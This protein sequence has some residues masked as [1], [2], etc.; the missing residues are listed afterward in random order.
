MAATAEIDDQ[1]WMLPSDE[2]VQ[3]LSNLID[4]DMVETALMTPARLIQAIEECAQLLDAQDVPQRERYVLVSRE[5]WRLAK[6]A[7]GRNMFKALPRRRG[8]RG[9]KQALSWSPTWKSI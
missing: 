4:A 5:W 1:G 8:A 9:R 6:R 2:A 7:I 3:E